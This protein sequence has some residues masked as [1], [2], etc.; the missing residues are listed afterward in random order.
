MERIAKAAILKDGVI[1]TPV[2]ENGRHNDIFRALYDAKFPAPHD[3]VQGFTTDAGRFVT[4]E[5]AV[6]I[7]GKAGQILAGREGVVVR[8]GR[9]YSE[10]VW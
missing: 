10:D 6:S 8:S 4:R 5:E 7:A 9:L 1:F 3:G 2:K